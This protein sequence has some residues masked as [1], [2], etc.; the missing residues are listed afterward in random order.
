[1]N[2]APAANPNTS[3]NQ[4]AW[5]TR[6]FTR[7]QRVRS[8]LLSKWW[9]PALGLAI[10]IGVE[11]SLWMTQKPT[12]ISSGRMI[13][14]M[15]LSIPEGSVYTEEWSNF[16]GTQAALMQSGAVL[17]QA[18]ARVTAENP[19]LTA[20]PVALKVTIL[21]KTTIFLLQ[22]TGDDPAYTQKFLQAC[23]EEYELLKIKMRTQTSD[24]TLAGLSEEVEQLRKDMAQSSKELEAFQGS[25]SVVV[26]DQQGNSAGNYLTALNQR[27]AGLKSEHD[28]LQTLSLEQN[29]ERRQSGGSTLAS[30]DQHTS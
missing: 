22:A 28:L 27:L 4:H 10:G 15:K 20:Q 23:M 1:M 11:T 21:P 13:V 18:H 12:F 30:P 8:L 6:F 16:L 26:L 29:L 3:Q 9:L 17:S 24:K 2:P 14:S 25:N 19:K 7:L 5:R